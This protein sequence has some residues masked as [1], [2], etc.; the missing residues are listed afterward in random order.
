M[1]TSS[2]LEKKA[3]SNGGLR[4]KLEGYKSYFYALQCHVQRVV[5]WKMATSSIYHMGLL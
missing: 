5:I 1:V 2:P 3:Y 4:G